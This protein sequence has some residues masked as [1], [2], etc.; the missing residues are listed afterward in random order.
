M[1]ARD[2][3]CSGKSKAFQAAGIEKLQGQANS[4][5]VIYKIANTV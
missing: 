5:L 1:S 3:P 4:K 2:S